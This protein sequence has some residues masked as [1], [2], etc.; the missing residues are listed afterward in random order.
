MDANVSS[1]E[2]VLG[3]L[4][5]A[6]VGDALGVPV[7]FKDRASVQAEPVVGMRGNGTHH[8]PPGTWSDD[9]SLTVCTVDSLVNTEF[10][11]ED[12]GRRFVRW[13][14]DGLW[15]ARGE[16]FDIGGTTADALM[17]IAKGTPAEEAGRTHEDS[18]GNGS[19]MRILP[20]VL[21]F[22]TEP[23]EKF[24]RRVER[25]SAITHGPERS[26]MACV[27]YALVV[28][29]LLFG[30]K[31]KAALD[32]ARMEFRRWY[33]RAP[34]L[35]RFYHHLADDFDWLSEELIVSTGYVLHTLHASLWCLLTTK[36]YRDC[37]LKAVNLGY[38]T[39]TTGCVAGGLA[40]A[41]YG[42][43]SIPKEWIDELARKGDL[44]CLFREFAD[45]CSQSDFKGTALE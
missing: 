29:H 38:D 1:T 14:Q 18:N 36:N 21:R 12:M 13:M 41:A 27:F 37:V 30:Q 39:D 15:T 2:R 9:G 45:L 11:T 23:M 32:A 17:R 16:V 4:W 40:G 5:G 31:P 24:S 42:I 7:E 6:L 33:E 34:A 26:K 8:Q 20:V 44:D 19:L 25:A 28:R 43:K 22:A 10:D 3:G 35:D